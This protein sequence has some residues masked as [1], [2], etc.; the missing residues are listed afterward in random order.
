MKYLCALFNSKLIK[1]WLLKKGKMLG[2]QFQIDKEPL[3]EIPIYVPEKLDEIFKITI[4]VDKLINT[5]INYNN[6]KTESDKTFYKNQILSL[7]ANID[8]F[9]YEFYKILTPDQLIIDEILDSL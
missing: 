6:S 4:L 7:E 5:N 1:F 3:L 8:N 9:I 2:S